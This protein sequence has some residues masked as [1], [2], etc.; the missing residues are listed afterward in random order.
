MNLHSLKKRHI[1]LTL[2]FIACFKYQ[3]VTSVFCG[4]IEDAHFNMFNGR[5]YEFIRPK[6]L[7]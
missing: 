4:Q 1:L 5:K 7:V 6:C 3:G 2:I